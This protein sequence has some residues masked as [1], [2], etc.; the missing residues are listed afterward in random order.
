MNAALYFELV[1]AVARTED[2]GQLAIVEERIAGTAMQ[3]IER[4]VLDR[5]VRARGEA[6]LLRH[7]VSGPTIRHAAS[8]DSARMG[9]RG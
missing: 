1:D 5:A 2:A 4:R 8:S 6:L 9:V 7:Q 3:P